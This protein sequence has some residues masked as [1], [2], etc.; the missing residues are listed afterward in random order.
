MTSGSGPAHSPAACPKASTHPDVAYC[1]DR[2][3]RSGVWEGD[4][5]KVEWKSMPVG[6]A[7]FVQVVSFLVGPYFYGFLWLGDSTR[8]TR[9]VCYPCHHVEH[10]QY[11]VGAVPPHTTTRH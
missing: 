3:R 5:V 6:S 2:I 10:D 8:T 9:S 4:E 11:S 1:A 7:V